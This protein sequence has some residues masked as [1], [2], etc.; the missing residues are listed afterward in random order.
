MAEIRL[1]GQL[2]ALAGGP[3][4]AV[5]GATV[6]DAL[7]VLEERLPAIGG[8]ILDERHMIRRHINVF[9]DGQRGSEDMPLRAETR[10]HVLPAITGGSA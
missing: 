1:S 2:Q 8:W 10:I 5:Q 3:V 7:I 4:H 6:R 9:V